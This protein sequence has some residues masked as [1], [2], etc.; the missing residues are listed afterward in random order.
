MCVYKAWVPC[1]YPDV[2]IVVCVCRI[3][4][5]Y[6]QELSK[7][8]TDVVGYAVF[9]HLLVSI[10]AYSQQDIFTLVRTPHAV[11][12]GRSG[13]CLDPFASVP[14]CCPLSSRT[15]YVAHLLTQAYENSSLARFIAEYS[16]W[17]DSVSTHQWPLV[18]ILWYDHTCTYPSPYGSTDPSLCFT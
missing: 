3:P 8:V 4:P 2:L 7:G 18:F 14:I 10:W 13:K 5:Q 11:V 1:D 15:V 17:T 16:T 9:L 6:G 12:R